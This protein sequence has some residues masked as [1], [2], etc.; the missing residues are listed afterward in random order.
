MNFS[1]TLG[2]PQ[3]RDADGFNFNFFKKLK[4][5]CNFNF[6]Y[7]SPLQCFLC[8]SHCSLSFKFMSSGLFEKILFLHT[9][10]DIHPSNI[11]CSV[12]CMYM[13]WGWPLVLITNWELC[14]GEDYF[15]PT[16][17]NPWLHVLVYLFHGWGPMKFSPSVLACPCSW[18]LY[19]AMLLIFHMH[20]FI[21]ISRRCD[22]T[23]DIL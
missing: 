14:P 23:A 5:K 22:L 3:E 17:S 20:N 21:D 4:L 15:F 13:I 8:P 7:P 1:F 6:P 2:R 10:T 11:N 18:Y 19:V 12:T 16:L 9:Q